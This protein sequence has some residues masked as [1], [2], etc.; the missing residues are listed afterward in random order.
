M[1]YRNTHDRIDE[2][3]AVPSSDGSRPGIV[4]EGNTGY[5][6]IGKGPM[7]SRDYFVPIS[8]VIHVENG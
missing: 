5:I 4:T 8:A 3:T 2:G 7:P 1:K 6:V